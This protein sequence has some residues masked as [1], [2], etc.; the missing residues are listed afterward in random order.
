MRLL[1]EWENCKDVF[2]RPKVLVYFGFWATPRFTGRIS[3]FLLKAWKNEGLKKTNKYKIYSWIFDHMKHSEDPGLPIWRRGNVIHLFRKHWMW[4]YRD[5]DNMVKWQPEFAEKLKK[6][7]LGWLKPEYELPLCLSCYFFKLPLMWKWKYDDVRHEYDPQLTFVLF[8][9]CLSFYWVAPY[10]P[11]STYDLYYWESIL[12]YTERIPEK[13]KN[14]S[15]LE[16]LKWVDDDMGAWVET[17]KD[18]QGNEVKTKI[19]NVQPEF[20]KDKTIAEEIR[21]YHETKK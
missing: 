10:R 6:L 15:V 5:R 2:K 17:K 21:K 4:D 11:T 3:A 12:N 13:L 19:W 18:E 20:L 16:K 9:I 1:K 7:H 14:T 8:N